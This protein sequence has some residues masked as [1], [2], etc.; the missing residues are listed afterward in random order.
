MAENKN[1]ISN[2][3]LIDGKLI[4]P[5]G[6]ILEKKILIEA[7]LPKVRNKRT[8]GMR[9]ENGTLLNKHQRDDEEFQ[10]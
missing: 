4:L 6:T 7:R 9:W 1:N 10:I 8:L 2:I 5:D 3:H